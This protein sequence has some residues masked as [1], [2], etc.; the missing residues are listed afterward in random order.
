[1]KEKD[2]MQL[3]AAKIKRPGFIS[4]NGGTPKGGFSPIFI[5]HTNLKDDSFWRYSS[6]DE[7]NT[8]MDEV[9]VLETIDGFVDGL[10]IAYD[11]DVKPLLKSV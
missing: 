10:R 2:I 7:F 11:R 3:L 8:E 6:T 1:M 9:T 4:K 5:N